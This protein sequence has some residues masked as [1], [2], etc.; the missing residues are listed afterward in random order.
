MKIK[1][2]ERMRESQQTFHRQCKWVMEDGL[3]ISHMYEGKSPDA[4]SWWADVGFILGN[5][6]VIVWW[7]H[8]RLSYD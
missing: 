8:P 5:R 6:R 1:R 4:L 7:Q 3:F 2:L